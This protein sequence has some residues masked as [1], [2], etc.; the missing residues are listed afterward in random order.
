MISNAPNVVIRL[1]LHTCMQKA[2]DYVH[3]F[4]LCTAKAQ[5]F[6]HF[7]LSAALKA[8]DKPVL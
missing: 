1:G 8:A 4:F 7:F 5:F 6:S 3:T 2:H